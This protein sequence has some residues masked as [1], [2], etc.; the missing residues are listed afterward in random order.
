MLHVAAQGDSVYSIA[1]FLHNSFLGVNSVDK[2]G[3]T[4]LHWACTTHSHAVV[5]FLLAWGADVERTDIVGY[6]PLH[7]ALRDLEQDSSKSLL[8]IK[9]LMQYKAP[10]MVLDNSGKLPVEYVQTYTD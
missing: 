5:K 8:T 3:S 1:F 9:L 6:T 4:P 2:S 10:L 7:L